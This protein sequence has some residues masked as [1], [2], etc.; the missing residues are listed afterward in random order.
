M[1]FKNENER[2]NNLE[3]ILNEKILFE[4]KIH[5]NSYASFSTS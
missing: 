3:L 4:K 2:K 5:K 1:L